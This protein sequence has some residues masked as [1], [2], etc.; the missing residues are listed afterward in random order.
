MDFINDD[1]H[2]FNDMQLVRTIVLLSM[3]TEKKH[4]Q[5]KDKALNL[6]LTNITTGKFELKRGNTIAAFAQAINLN[7]NLYFGQSEDIPLEGYISENM[8]SSTSELFPGST[9]LF[10]FVLHHRLLKV[11][12]LFIPYLQEYF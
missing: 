9:G 12:N 1:L 5:Q 2:T 10:L 4:A 8:H 7:F 3:S 11:S 6:L